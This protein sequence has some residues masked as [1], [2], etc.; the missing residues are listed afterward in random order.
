MSTTHTAPGWQEAVFGVLKKGN[1]AQIAYVPDAGHPHTLGRHAPPALRRAP[2][3]RGVILRI[4]DKIR[5]MLLRGELRPGESI[6]QELPTAEMGVS[7]IPTRES[8]RMPVAEGVVLH[9]RSAG[10]AV[11]KLTEREL[12]ECYFI[13]KVLET[14]RLERIEGLSPSQESVLRDVNRRLEKALR[15]GD[16][17][18][19]APL[20]RTF[21]FA[22]STPR[23]A[24]EHDQMIKLAK[25]GEIESLVPATDEHR[26][27]G[28]AR[29]LR[30]LA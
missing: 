6:R 28:E 27:A 11:A 1:V 25:R 18:E 26:A 13:R 9:T 16:V 19:S 23:I 7:R 14:Q 10:Y 24:T 20:N 17:V 12:S 3:H 15:A 29:V 5:S 4:R 22:M 21:H 2:R 8:L 30:T